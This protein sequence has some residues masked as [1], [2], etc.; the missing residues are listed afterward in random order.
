MKTA[1]KLTLQ[2]A[3]AIWIWYLA[4]QTALQYLT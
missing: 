4:T 2:F 1:V 3:C